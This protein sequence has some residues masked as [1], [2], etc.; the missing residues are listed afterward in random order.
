MEIP[1]T[2][3]ERA[4]NRKLGI[5]WIPYNSALRP[6]VQ[7]RVITFCNLTDHVENEV[8]WDRLVLSPS[9]AVGGEGL[10]TAR[11]LGAGRGRT[12]LVVWSTKRAGF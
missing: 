3:A 11:T 1:L 10:E 4:I 12:L 2:A 7:D 5:L 9:R 6:T 8:G